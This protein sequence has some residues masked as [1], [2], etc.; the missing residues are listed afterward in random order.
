[1]RPQQARHPE[2]A[3]LWCDGIGIEPVRPHRIGIPV[4][5]NSKHLC[6]LTL[7]AESM[8]GID[9]K[10]QGFA[11]ALIRP[12]LLAFEGNEPKV[13]PAHDEIAPAR[14]TRSEGHRRRSFLYERSRHTVPFQ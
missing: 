3:P 13:L 11:L 14:S 1:M 7:L 5:I 4:F 2:L 8:R 6:C 10:Q 12:E 9:G